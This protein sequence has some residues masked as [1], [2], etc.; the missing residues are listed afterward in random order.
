MK[1][2]SSVLLFSLSLTPFASADQII[3]ASERGWVC[4]TVGGCPNNNGADPGNN[5]LAGGGGLGAVQFRDWFE[6]AIP[7]LTGSLVSAT[8]NLDEP[9]AVSGGVSG[10]GHGGG[11]LTYAVYGLSAQPLAFLDV[12]TANPFALP[13]TTSSA[14]DGTTISITL[15]SAALAAIAAH[16][17]GH[18]FIGGID[19]GESSSTTAYDFGASDGL[20][21]VTSLRLTTAPTAV[22]EPS[23]ILLVAS[24]GLL[25]VVLRRKTS[26]I[27]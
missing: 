1:R 9:P 16:Q 5:Y 20:S 6:F 21:N 8:L 12:T 2:L 15:N 7:T 25:L 27:S 22:P 26:R 19:S 14:D 17:G 4:T 18:I 24:V 13:V 3:N 23:S 10:G 11:S